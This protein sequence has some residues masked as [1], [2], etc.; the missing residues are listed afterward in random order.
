MNLNINS[1]LTLNNG[2]EIP[3]LGLG[4]LRI[5]G[6]NLQKAILWAIEAGYR[7]IDTAKAYGNEVARAH[8]V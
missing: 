5:Q 6:E 1:K 7:H 8:V 2:V 4:T 3:V